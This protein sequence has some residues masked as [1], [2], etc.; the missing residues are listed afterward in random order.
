MQAALNEIM[1]YVPERDS[2]TIVDVGANCGVWT[3]EMLKR[4]NVERAILF[5]PIKT[6]A[7]YAAKKF[8]FS[9]SITVE[10]FALSDVEEQ[11]VI[12]CGGQAVGGQGHNL[13]WNTMI[14]ERINEEN[15]GNPVNIEC[16]VFDDLNKSIYKLNKIDIMKIDTEGYEYKIFNGMLETLASLE[17]KPVIVCEIGWGKQH[18]YLKE[19]EEVLGKIG[20]IGYFNKEIDFDGTKDI[21]ILPR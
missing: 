2:Y 17:R 3:E 6:Y 16:K 18:P 20:E 5:E 21:F 9:D 15:A 10:N 1:E 11:Q 8:S 4:V 14:A 13:G 7:D 19:L 12:Y